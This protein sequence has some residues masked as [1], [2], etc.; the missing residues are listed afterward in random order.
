MLN[1]RLVTVARGLVETAF[2]TNSVR[3]TGLIRRVCSLQFIR[4]KIPVWSMASSFRP[5]AY[6]L[7]RIVSKVLSVSA[8]SIIISMIARDFVRIA[9]NGLLRAG[10]VGTLDN[11]NPPLRRGRMA[12]FLRPFATPAPGLA[13]ETGSNEAV[14]WRGGRCLAAD[15]A[16]SQGW[17]GCPGCGDA[18]DNEELKLRRTHRLPLP[19]RKQRRTCIEE[20]RNKVTRSR[21]T[22]CRGNNKRRSSSKVN[23]WGGSTPLNAAIV[24]HHLAAFYVQVC[25][26]WE[27]M[28]YSLRASAVPLPCV[29]R[30][31]IPPFQRPHQRRCAYPAPVDNRKSE[32]LHPRPA[33]LRARLPFPGRN[34]TATA[35]ACFATV[36]LGIAGAARRPSDRQF[37]ADGSPAASAPR[38]PAFFLFTDGLVPRR[39][40]HI[41]FGQSFPALPNLT[42]ASCSP[43]GLGVAGQIFELARLSHGRGMATLTW[44]FK[45]DRPG[46]QIGAWLALLPSI[47]HRGLV[48]Y[49]VVAGRLGPD[50]P[51]VLAVIPIHPGSL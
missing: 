39:C 5:V 1:A 27:K 17:T 18:A 38:R 29:R 37:R 31:C 40:R 4:R 28:A 3:S 11:R 20:R 41:A 50:P 13:D 23:D 25:G 7:A 26:N 43:P 49:G 45:R 6:Q 48:G 9:I 12:Q 32:A 33:G 24:L 44:R 46:G 2:P 10:L 30:R 16:K 34:M 42:A 22:T 47:K 14:K 8:A 21:K 36:R 15:T 19:L 51:A 35:A